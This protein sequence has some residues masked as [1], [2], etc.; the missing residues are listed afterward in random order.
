MDQKAFALQRR[1]EVDK[2]NFSTRTIYREQPADSLTF[3]LW[4]TSSSQEQTCECIKVS[5]L[6]VL[7]VHSFSLFLK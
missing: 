3:P 7:C 5:R 1:T 6:P 4:D 2:I